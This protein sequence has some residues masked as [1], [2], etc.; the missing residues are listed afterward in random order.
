M[1]TI[2]ITNKVWPK[3]AKALG[4]PDNLKVTM[5]TITMRPEQ[6]VKV[7]LDMIIDKGATDFLVNELR[8]YELKEKTK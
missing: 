7:T 4:I 2:A 6:C 8:H 3:F 1:T 5:C